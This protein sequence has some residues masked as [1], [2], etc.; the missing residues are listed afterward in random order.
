VATIFTKLFLGGEHGHDEEL[1]QGMRQTLERVKQI[2]ESSPI[3]P[4]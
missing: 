3:T 4:G 1:R 2:A